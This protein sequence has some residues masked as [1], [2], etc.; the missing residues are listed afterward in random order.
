MASEQSSPF[1]S[2]HSYRVRPG[3]P[4]L[5]VIPTSWVSTFVPIGIVLEVD[6]RP[7]LYRSTLG[8]L[9][10]QRHAPWLVVV[11]GPNI[12]SDAQNGRVLLT[13]QEEMHNTCVHSCHDRDLLQPSSTHSRAL[14]TIPEPT[15]SIPKPHSHSRLR[16]SIPDHA[17]SLP[18]RSGS[19][20][21]LVPISR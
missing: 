14:S 3:L 1:G 13:A 6:G 11:V 10:W 4:G 8:T 19:T 17:R 7:F 15:S 20:R 18:T 12:L 21:S 5:V 9:H 2:F 16:T